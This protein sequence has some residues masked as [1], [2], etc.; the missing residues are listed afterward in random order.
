MPDSKQ[1]PPN[2]ARIQQLL[3]EMRSHLDTMERSE[4]EAAKC[5]RE[6][7]R[8]LPP[9]SPLLDWLNEKRSR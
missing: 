2:D 7:E 8:L 3:A 9:D 1:G 4:S 6:L 5:R